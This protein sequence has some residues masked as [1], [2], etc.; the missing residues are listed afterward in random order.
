MN[1][2]LQSVTHKETGLYD[3][4][5]SPLK[6]ED[7]SGDNSDHP[8]IKKDAPKAIRLNTEERVGNLL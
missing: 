7:E 1:I 4:I 5:P 6:H 3:T 2:R 8:K